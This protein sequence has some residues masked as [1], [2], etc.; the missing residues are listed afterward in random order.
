MSKLISQETAATQDLAKQKQEL[1]FFF[2]HGHKY[3]SVNQWKS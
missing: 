2:Y 1:N 3:K